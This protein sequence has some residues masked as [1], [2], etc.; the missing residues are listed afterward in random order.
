MAAYAEECRAEHAPSIHP[1]D[2]KLLQAHPQ[3]SLLGLLV[4]GAKENVLDK[5]EAALFTS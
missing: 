3:S 5:P 2:V 1:A 4:T